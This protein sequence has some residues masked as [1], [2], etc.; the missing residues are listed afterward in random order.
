M[1]H[2]VHIV[3]ELALCDGPG[4]LVVPLEGCYLGA[5]NRRAAIAIIVHAPMVYARQKVCRGEQ[6][7]FT[8]PDTT[9][10]IVAGLWALRR[11]QSMH[12]V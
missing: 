2:L 4:L 11:Q 7:D 5:N 8:Y 6:Y 1:P 3:A 12:L 10:G 9:G